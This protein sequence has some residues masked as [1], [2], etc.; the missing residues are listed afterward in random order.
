LDRSA[1]ASRLIKE[2]ENDCAPAE[3]RKPNRSLEQPISR[4]A[5]EGKIRR[6]IVDAWTCWGGG[7]DW[8]LLTFQNT[9]CRNERGGAEQPFL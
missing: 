6:D 8:S 7:D 5:A 2:G 9:G 4:T 3:V 1:L